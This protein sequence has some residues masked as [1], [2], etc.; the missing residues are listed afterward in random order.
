[1]CVLAK[2][3]QSFL[4]LCDPCFGNDQ[5]ILFLHFVKIFSCGLVWRSGCYFHLVTGISMNHLS[6]KSKKITYL[7]L[8]SL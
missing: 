2:S 1:M 7:L 6:R 3:L 8:F 5:E 4:T